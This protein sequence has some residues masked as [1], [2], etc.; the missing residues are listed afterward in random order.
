MLVYVQLLDDIQTDLLL[1][2]VHAVNI[3]QIVGVPRPFY[4]FQINAAGAPVIDNPRTVTGLSDD[5]WERPVVRVVAPA[6]PKCPS[7]QCLSGLGS[8][9]FRQKVILVYMQTFHDECTQSRWL[10]PALAKP[11][12]SKR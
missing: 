9:N 5:Q 2:D 4:P 12:S 10:V 8:I 7:G 6:S 11:I 1:F 3:H